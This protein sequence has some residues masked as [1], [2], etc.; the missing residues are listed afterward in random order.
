MSEHQERIGQ[1]VGDYRLLRWLGGGSFGNVYQA[2]HIRNGDQVAVKVLQ[3]RLTDKEDFRTFLNE[4]RT[5][6]LHHGLIYIT[7]GDG[8]L[9]AFD[10]TTGQQRW[11][12]PSGDVIYSSPT[13]ANGLVFVGS[14]DG[15]LYAFD[16]LTGQQRWA[17]HTG[18]RIGSSP[19]IANGLVYIG[20]GDGKLY[21]FSLP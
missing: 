11:V 4:A 1:I 13:I 14:R 17:A 12:A 2:E 9:Y 10:A 19:A 20:S 16:A 21:S 7:S 5:I 8:S 15:K 18:G 3:V 6:R